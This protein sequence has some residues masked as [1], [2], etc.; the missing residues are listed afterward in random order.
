LLLVFE[1][2]LDGLAATTAG[3]LFGVSFFLDGTLLPWCLHCIL[4]G[5]RAPGVLKKRHGLQNLERKRVIGSSSRFCVKSE[6]NMYW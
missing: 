2:G 1:A 3:A 5:F 6:K 4:C